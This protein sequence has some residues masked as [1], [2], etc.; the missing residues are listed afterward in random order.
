[1]SAAQLAGE[2]LWD[3]IFYRLA[4]G[5]KSEWASLFSMLQ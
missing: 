2:S 5:F 3:M 4:P 1:V